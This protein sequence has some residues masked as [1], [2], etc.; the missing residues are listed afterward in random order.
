MHTY[1]YTYILF[2]RWIMSIILRFTCIIRSDVTQDSYAIFLYMHT[3]GTF[4]IKQYHGVLVLASFIADAVV[5]SDLIQCLM[6]DLK[7]INVWLSSGGAFKQSFLI[8]DFFGKP[9]Q[10]WTSQILKRLWESSCRDVTS[11]AVWTERQLSEQLAASLAVVA[12]AVLL[13][14]SWVWMIWQICRSK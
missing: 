1:M 13:T 11:P 9:L 4:R 12:H 3:P 2:S 14:Q 8:C 5:M 10:N 6:S 7:I